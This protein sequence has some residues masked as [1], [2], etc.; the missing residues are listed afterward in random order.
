MLKNSMRNTDKNMHKHFP[1]LGPGRTQKLKGKGPC[2]Q[3]TVQ[4]ATG[5]DT[6]SPQAGAGGQ[7]GEKMQGLGG[8]SGGALLV[9]PDGRGGG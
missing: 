3:D 7:G 8:E 4:R 6:S 1:K 5:A 9:E 2:D